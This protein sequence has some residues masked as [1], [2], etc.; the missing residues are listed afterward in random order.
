MLGR[1]C[2]N[3]FYFIIW[4]QHLQNGIIFKY[5]GFLC[6]RCPAVFIMLYSKTSPEIKYLLADRVLK[7]VGECKSKKHR[8]HTDSGSYDGQPDDKP[9]KRLLAVKGYSACNKWSCIQAK[10]L[11]I[12]NIP[13]AGSLKGL[14]LFPEREYKTTPS[15]LYFVFTNNFVFTEL[16]PIF[17]EV[18]NNPTWENRE[19][20]RQK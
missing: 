1:K 5:G 2:L 8:S 6:N 7:T 19:P 3:S 9:W 16:I 15:I 13:I 10:V 4:M 11:I 20:S 14:F 18:Q 17:A 12:K